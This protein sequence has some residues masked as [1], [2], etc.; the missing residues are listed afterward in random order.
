MEK[1]LQDLRKLCADLIASKNPSSEYIDSLI[2]KLSA[3]NLS[4]ETTKEILIQIKSGSKIIDY[5]NFNHSQELQWLEIWKE[6]TYLLEYK[7]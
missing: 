7:S 3:L 6:A 5:A 4:K 1:L 2:T